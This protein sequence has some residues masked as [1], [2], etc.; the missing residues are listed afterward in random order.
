MSIEYVI[1][2]HYYVKHM[3][4][5][6]RLVCI[7]MDAAWMCTVDDEVTRIYM[8]TRLDNLEKEKVPLPVPGSR[9]DGN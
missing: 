6:F 1:G 3:A 4:Q 8:S 2:E 5:K 9:S 7:D